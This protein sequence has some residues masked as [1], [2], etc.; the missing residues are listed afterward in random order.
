VQRRQC[1]TEWWTGWDLRCCF[2]TLFCPNRPINDMCYVAPWSL[3]SHEDRNKVPNT[4]LKS[5][6][7]RVASRDHDSGLKVAVI[8]R[9]PLIPS[10]ITVSFLPSTQKYPLCLIHLAWTNKLELYPTTRSDPRVSQFSLQ[11]W[12]LEFSSSQSGY[13][14][15]SFR[16][17]NSML[18]TGHAPL[19]L[20]VYLD[21]HLL[22]F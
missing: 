10:A 19:P 1:A 7:H 14:L 6:L 4:T 9:P 11:F 5:G 21:S 15:A 17:T 8:R 20:C 3:E 18:P 12:L 16:D 13:I 2:L 22:Q